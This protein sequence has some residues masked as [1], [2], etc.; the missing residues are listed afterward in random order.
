MVSNRTGAGGAI[1]VAY[2]AR[3]APDGY[4]L[5]FVPAL[6]YS[7][8]PLMQSNVGYTDKSFAPICQTF[9]NQM[10]L[11][12]RPGFAVQD[13]ARHRRGGAGQA[14]GLAFA[15]T[16]VGT[17]T[18]LAGG[19]ARRHRQGQVQPR[20]VPRRRRSDGPVDRRARRFR[21]RHARLGGGGRAIGAGDRRSLP[22]RATLRCRTLPTVKEQGYDVAPTSFGGLFAPAG[23]PGDVLAKLAAGCKF[24]V[25]Q[26]AYVD[27]AKQLPPGIELLR[28]RRDLRQ[29][30]RRRTSPTSKSCCSAS[31]CIK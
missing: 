10:A 29:A 9:E 22:M 25:E 21:Q 5:L 11:I 31:A 19:C 17:I 28:R 8:L 3:S 26:P 13:R 4:T 23:V 30:A 18:H 24:A 14:D 7:V 2:V 16:A 1:G 6:A 12:V 27:L 15:A 20:P